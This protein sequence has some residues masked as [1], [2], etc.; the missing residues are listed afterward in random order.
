MSVS[1]LFG[2]I[3]SLSV[4]VLAIFFHTENWR[5]FMDMPSIVIVLGGALATSFLTFRGRYVFKALWTGILTFRGQKI[6]SASLASDVKQFVVWAR[7]LN[8]SGLEGLQSETKGDIFLQRAIYLAKQEY[9][10][11]DF[12]EMMQDF[13]DS[14]FERQVVSANILSRFG[15]ISPAFGMVGTLIGMVLMLGAMGSNPQ[16]VGAGMSV[17]LTATLYGLLLAK[18]VFEPMAGKIREILSIERFRRSLILEGFALL[19]ARKDPYYI[20]DRLNCKLDPKHI[21][22]FEAERKEASGSKN[23]KAEKGAEKDAD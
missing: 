22:D 3:A 13:I 6:T 4:F 11:A 10:E 7:I 21:Y 14:D 16:G 1:S 8:K 18:M 15:T 17:A 23:G 9:S 5:I 12:R 2:L 19:L 20:M